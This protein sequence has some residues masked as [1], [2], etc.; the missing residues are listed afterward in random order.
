MLNRKTVFRHGLLLG[1]LALGLLTVPSPGRAE[2]LYKLDTTC[3]IKGGAPMP[4]TVVATNEGTATLYKHTLAASTETIR[5]KDAP[6]R[7]DRWLTATK[8]WQPLSQAGARFSTNTVCFNGL[9]FCVVNPNY[10]NSVR[11]SNPTATAE[12]DLVRVHFGADGRV[13]I[14]CYDDGCAMF[15]KCAVIQK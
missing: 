3:T 1:G 5:V 2:V 15:Q 8:E 12:R 9:D 6:I 11:E 4:C 14:T 10:L 13:D 7:M